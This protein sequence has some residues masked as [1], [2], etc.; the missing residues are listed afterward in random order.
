[1]GPKRKPIASTSQPF[2]GVSTGRRQTQP[3]SR[4]RGRRR[5]TRPARP[6][7]QQPGSRGARWTEWFAVA[8]HEI[9]SSTSEGPLDAYTLHPLTLPTSP[10]ATQLANYTH[11]K[12]ER[13]EFRIYMTTA[14]TTGS[15]VAALVVPDPTHATRL[16]SDMVWGAICN[17]RGVMVDSTG[18]MSRDSRFAVQSATVLLS[19][20]A[21]PGNESY[22]GYTAGTLTL[23]L[24]QRPIG[25]NDK[26]VLLKCTVMARCLCRGVN[27]IPGF[28]L[29]QMGL[30]TDA[31]QPVGQPAWQ[32][33]RIGTS[34]SDNTRMNSLSDEPWV[35]SHIGNLPLAGGYYFDFWNHKGKAPIYNSGSTNA[36]NGYSK[37]ITIK[38]VPKT[39][40]VYTCSTPFPPWQ[41]NRGANIVP[42][43]F[44][45]ISGVVSSTVLMV[46]FATQADAENQA[47][48]RWMAIPPGAELCI[49]Y[50]GAPTWGDFHPLTGGSQ[51]NEMQLTFYELYTTQYAAPVYSSTNSP[52][53]QPFSLFAL[54]TAE[55]PQPRELTPSEWDDSDE[56]DDQ[57]DETDPLEGTSTQ[58][59]PLQPSA[60]PITPPMDFFQ[61]SPEQLDHEIRQANDHLW[62]LHRARARLTSPYADLTNQ[63]SQ[64]QLQQD[65][66]PQ[67]QAEKPPERGSWWDLLKDA[68]RRRRKDSD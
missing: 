53:T 13:W 19:N 4:G 20:A 9:T 42:K 67:R 32:M 39:C 23:W 56:E 14:S 1:M 12:E 38:G 58:Y 8:T 29:A 59:Q 6:A 35:K 25:L 60:P 51:A 52:M 45:I 47:L 11:R 37:G 54:P 17:N 55:E 36:T 40:T 63:L 34:F 15:R 61:L 3:G 30:G 64:L 66:P 18:N 24:L 10:Y 26:N 22:L 31:L 48:N 44:T 65:H 46:G 5:G 57:M 28:Q 41:N 7:T 43:Y 21:L 16:T 27:P 49:R 62:Q 68:V 2:T 50:S 33:L